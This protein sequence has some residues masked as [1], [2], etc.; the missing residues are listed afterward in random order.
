MR[1]SLRLYGSVLLLCSVLNAQ[2]TSVVTVAGGYQGNHKPAVSASFAYPS[3]L[4]FDAA[5]TL[6]IG[7]SYNCEIRR[8]EKSGSVEV[9]A[10][11]G[12]CGFSGDGGKARSA[13]LSSFIG[14]IVF[15]GNGDLLFSDSGN[16]RVRQI[17]PAGV[18]STI[19]GIGTIGYSGDGGPANQAQLFFPEDI[20]LDSLGNLYVADDDNYVVRKIN[21]AGI[22]ST[23]AGNH[24]SGYSGD[25]G[26]ATAAQLAN[27]KGLAVDLAGNLYI[28]DGASHVRE[29]NSAG[30]ISTI[31]GNGQNGNAG[32]G[33]PGT[34]A[35][36]GGVSALSM[37]GSAVLCILTNSSLWSL[38]LATNTINLLAGAAGGI[39]F[40]GDGGSALSAV[41]MYPSG[42]AVDSQGNILLADSGNNRIREIAAGSQ[43]IGTVAGGYIGDGQKATDA[44]LDLSSQGGHITFDRSGN[45][46]IADTANHRVRKVSSKGT[47]TTV[48][49]NGTMGYSGDGGPATAAQLSHPS[50]VVMDSQG[51]LFI[52]DA[53][54]G[55]IR[56][57]DP[58][59][60]I[61][62]PQI[63]GPIFGSYI[64]EWGAGMAID[65]S[66]NIYFSD[67]LTVVWKLD[68]ANN[69]SIVAGTLWGFGSSGDGG[70]A[71]QATIF[72][73]LGVAVDTAGNL[74]ISEW[75]GHR[76]R[77]VDSSG[78]ITT[79]A[80][81][82][83][84]G[85]SGDGGPASAA[86]L[87][88]PVDLATDAS[89]NLYI[90]DW[91]NFRVRMVDT[92]GTIQTVVGSGKYGY[93]GERLAP[94]QVDVFPQGLAFDTIE[95]LNFADGSS[96]RIRKIDK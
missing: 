43:N 3:A 95:E 52:A 16:M 69:A 73:P 86:L 71:T 88:Y 30:I 89:G 50:A 53:G 20:T 2:K 72:F 42:L 18:I 59:G 26:L 63:N 31:A 10:G 39:G 9:F 33:G 37:K 93:N 56:K 83:T 85:F 62:T 49:G 35:A 7:D 60:T 66:D 41:F 36:I 94:N 27:V 87:N 70:P 91:L 51:N 68:P 28:G 82:G 67:G 25:G 32:D 19:A 46:Y 58:N 92:T 57:V 22:I 74:Y 96:N 14:G 8:I 23:V 12:I 79:V 34:A 81:N 6:Y 77:R 64:F 13:M 48:A 47:I 11:T 55:R 1:L 61:T 45:L 84:P 15:D 29:V 75:L 38:D 17:T 78:T 24:T 76:V 90:A 40:N 21:T 5:G 65:S 80:G 54:N 4:A 44:S